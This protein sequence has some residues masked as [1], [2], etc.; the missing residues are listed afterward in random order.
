MTQGKGGVVAEFQDANGRSLHYSSDGENW[1]EWDLP[2]GFDSPPIVVDD[3]FYVRELDTFHIT[4]DGSE[5]WTL[6]LKYFLGD[7]DRTTIV[8]G[9]G[10]FA[11]L[12]RRGDEIYASVTV[13]HWSV[14]TIRT[15]VEWKG[16]KFSD[17]QFFLW[18]SDEDSSNPDTILSS[19]D[20]KNWSAI[21]L[22]NFV[23]GVDE[24][25]QVNGNIV[26]RQISATGQTTTLDIGS[27]RD[28]PV[29]FI[30]DFMEF[31]PGETVFHPLRISGSWTLLRAYGLPRGLSFDSNTG[32]IH[33]VAL[34]EPYSRHDVIFVGENRGMPGIV[35]YSQIYL[36]P[37]R[38]SAPTI[39]TP[40]V[41]GQVGLRL[42]G[43]DLSFGPEDHSSQVVI[44]GAP[45][46]LSFDGH[47]FVGIPTESADTTLM[48]EVSN[49]FGTTAK[50][51]RLII[52]KPVF[53]R[54]D[55]PI[56]DW[57]YVRGFS[58]FKGRYFISDN[59]ES[60]WSWD[61]KNWTPVAP[62]VTGFENM[63]SFKEYIYIIDQPRVYKSPDGRGWIWIE[64][65]PEIYNPRPGSLFATGDKLYLVADN[66]L[67]SSDNGRDWTVLE[68]GER[69]PGY[70]VTY[71]G[72]YFFAYWLAEDVIYRSSDALSWEV[73]FD[74]ESDHLDIM[75]IAYGNG[76]YL[77]IAEDIEG[78]FPILRSTDGQNW[79]KLEAPKN[80]PRSPSVLYFSDGQFHIWGNN[81]WYFFSEDGLSWKNYGFPNRNTTNSPNFES[82]FWDGDFLYGI[83][84]SSGIYRRVSDDVPPVIDPSHDEIFILGQPADLPINLEG[85]VNRVEL[86][87]APKGLSFDLS[88][89]KIVGI[90]LEGGEF[91]ACMVAYNDET[92]SQA[93]RFFGAVADPTKVPNFTSDFHVVAS[94]DSQVQIAEG[95]EEYS[96]FKLSA[97]NLPNQFR[98]S[99][100]QLRWDYVPAGIY[101]TDFTLT[102]PNGS[103]QRSKRIQLYVS[104]IF[105]PLL[106]K[107]SLHL[108]GVVG[109][110]LME[111]VILSG[112]T[113]VASVSRLPGGLSYNSNQQLIVGT[114]TQSG[115]FVVTVDLAGQFNHF[116]YRLTIEDNLEFVQPVQ[117]GF[118][119]DSGTYVYRAQVEDPQSYSFQWFYSGYALSDNDTISGSNSPILRLNSLDNFDPHKFSVQVSHGGLSTLIEAPFNATLEYYQYWADSLQ[120]TG[121]QADPLAYG[122]ATGYPN[123]FLFMQGAT[124]LDDFIPPE[125]IRTLGGFQFKFVTTKYWNAEDLKILVSKDLRKDFFEL[126]PLMAEESQTHR[127]W[128]A[129]V[130][131]PLS[132]RVFL[133]LKLVWGQP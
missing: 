83:D 3:T 43:Q 72:Q 99:D 105:S 7:V 130:A 54:L 76:V 120:L 96:G 2:M 117:G 57:F 133:T 74:E 80:F 127:T 113:E 1:Q 90:P 109:I 58:Y 114:P 129:T 111:S 101:P 68:N 42:H 48:V 36:Q 110:P 85:E 35:E 10:V 65:V 12:G 30:P 106:E 47:S 87:G 50:E 102:S 128:F 6:E 24:V 121:R 77:A 107:R 56:G 4:R 46:W 33:G 34:E 88:S 119:R 84:F 92:Y 122:N 116:F 108:R 112:S 32:A 94:R 73:V 91:Q 100:F 20:G 13:E 27:K 89:G 103:V 98:I 61:L 49:Q 132:N 78:K 44:T 51:I 70:Y 16:L 55:R 52:N 23:Q 25:Y 26:A 29:F 28:V 93:A 8:Y 104:P 60:Y 59:F 64:N 131:D 63:V 39:Y 9:N 81:G 66:R 22:G 115:D 123:I 5:W 38:A 45:S 41:T 118:D 19:S 31:P 71:K 40:C 67:V 126:R 53:E 86:Y 62:D 21:N 69:P 37:M 125:I 18:G 15:G 79:E 11:A 95:G 14:Q 82:F 97:E 17:G 124:E 75:D